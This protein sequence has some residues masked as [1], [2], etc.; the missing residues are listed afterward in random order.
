MVLATVHPLHVVQAVRCKLGVGAVGVAGLGLDDCPALALDDANATDAPLGLDF[1]ALV[2][3]NVTL[4]LEL[5][6]AVLYSVGFADDYGRP[7]GTVP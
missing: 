7:L 1:S 3:T 6:G 2:G 5:V 4:E